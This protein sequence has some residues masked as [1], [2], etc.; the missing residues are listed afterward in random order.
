MQQRGSHDLALEAFRKGEVQILLGTQMIA[1][2][3]DFPNVTLVGVIDADTLLHQPDL[4][5]SE[6]TF[7]LIAQVAG[8]TGRSRRG[9][10]VYVQTACPQHPAIQC[11]ARHDYLGFVRT[12]L[13]HREEFHYPPYT[14]LVRVILRGPKETEVSTAASKLA[15]LLR[16]VSRD[17]RRS[18]PLRVAANPG[19]IRVQGPAPCQV[20][21]LQNRFRYHVLLSSPILEDLLSLWKTVSPQ[22]SPGTDIESAV[23]VDPIN[24]R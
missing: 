24:L 13:P 14:H 17:A 21:K 20:T 7:Q 8:R 18:V 9:G 3:L 22:W 2:G 6:R 12:E 19:S 15:T 23:D 1:K 4:R 16:E 11:A 10:R 5:A